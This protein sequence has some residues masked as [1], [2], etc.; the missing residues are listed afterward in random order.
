VVFSFAA[1]VFV[2]CIIWAKCAGPAP[3]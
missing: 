3:F 2:G 1:F